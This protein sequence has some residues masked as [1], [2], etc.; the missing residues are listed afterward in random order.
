MSFKTTSLS[1]LA[2]QKFQ[3]NF[4]GVLSFFI[5][6]FYAVVAL[7]AYV[8]APDDTQYANQMHISIHSQPPGFTVDMLALPSTTAET[9]FWDWWNGKKSTLQEIP[10]ADLKIEKGTIFYR[11][12]DVDGKELSFVDANFSVGK[13]LELSRFRESYTS[14]NISIRDRQIWS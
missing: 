8:L 13:D 9:S 6:L 7:F 5:I 11:P 10:Y 4:W 3:K 2:L 12:F 1:S 14:Q